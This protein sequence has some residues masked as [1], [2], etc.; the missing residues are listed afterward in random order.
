M[1]ARGIPTA[2]VVGARTTGTAAVAGPVAQGACGVVVVGGG[3]VVAVGVGS[4]RDGTVVCPD[5]GGGDSGSTDCARAS[6][7][8]TVNAVKIAIVPGVIFEGCRTIV[9]ANWL[10]KQ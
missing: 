10:F 8:Q 2:T 4:T 7:A 9:A 1:R 6:S 5:T 3:A